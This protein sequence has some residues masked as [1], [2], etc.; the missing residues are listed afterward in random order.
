MHAKLMPVNEKERILSI[1]ILRGFALLGIFLVNMP[2]FFNPIYYLNPQ[3]YWS[4]GTDYNLHAFVDFFAQGSFYPLFAFL[5]G[6]GAMII[7]ERSGYKQLSFPLLFVR[8]LFILLVFGCIHA[9]LVWH[10]DILIS[11]ACTG[12]LFMLFYKCSGKTLIVS[13]LLIYIIPFGLLAWLFLLINQNILY[14]TSEVVTSIQVYSSESFLDITAQRMNDWLH[15]NGPN[16][17][18]VLI[19]NLLPI[20]LLGAGFAKQKWLIHVKEYKKQLI[21]LMWIGLLGGSAFKILPYIQGDTYGARFLQDQFGGPLLA[22]FYMTSIVLLV[23]NKIAR[24]I[25]KPLASVGRMSISHYLVQSIIFT[26]ISYGYGLGYYGDISYTTGF[27]FVFIFYTI[28][29]IVSHWWLSKYQYGP[30]EYIWRWVTYGEKPK[31]SRKIER[32][33]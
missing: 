23:E 4:K 6:Y 29:V 26:S 9:F 27:I 8:R 20:M 30:I 3:T 32:A 5:F 16:N 22:L 25:L 15:A 31:L 24:K 28:Q 14:N 12:F 2:A 18:W 7:A 19:L 10:G 13:G 17:A 11:Y 33:G 1:D 21:C